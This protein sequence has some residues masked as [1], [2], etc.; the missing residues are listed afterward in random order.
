MHEIMVRPL[1][2]GCRMTAI[3]DVSVF[4]ARIYCSKGKAN[5]CDYVVLSFRIRSWF[6]SLTLLQPVIILI[7]QSSRIQICPILYVF[8]NPNRCSTN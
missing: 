2:P 3:F 8:S 7:E 4:G 6:V 1:P 5:F